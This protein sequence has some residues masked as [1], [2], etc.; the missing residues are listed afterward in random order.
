[1]LYG[2]GFREIQHHAFNGTKLDQVWVFYVNS[3]NAFNLTTVIGIVRHFGKYACSLS[4]W[5]LEEKID[6]TL[7]CEL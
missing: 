6:T 1:M 2:N 7:M 3:L 5:E 4:C